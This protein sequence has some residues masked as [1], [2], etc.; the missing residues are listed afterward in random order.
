[1]NP[2]GH[3]C[4]TTIDATFGGTQTM[5]WKTRLSLAAA[6]VGV[7][8]ALAACGGATDNA[9]TGTPGGGSTVSAREIDGVGRALTGPD[10][11]TLYFAEAE[12]H[13]TIACQNNCLSFWTPLTVPAGTAP[14]AGPGVTGTLA[15]LSRPDGEV[16]VTLD[17]KP[18]YSFAEDGGPGQAKG[19]GFTDT[20]DGTELVWRAA[21]VS[22]TAPT[23]QPPADEPDTGGNGY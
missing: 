8:L 18:L 14:T 3:P 22:G 16:Q 19:N 1:M 15:V 2:D 11:K 17:G 10:G 5:R 13:G 12:A 6:A 20:F 9:S 21:T 4:R 23:G 7:A